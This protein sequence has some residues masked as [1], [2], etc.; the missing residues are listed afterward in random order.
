M[1]QA[2][3]DAG[4]EKR[5]GIRDQPRETGLDHAPKQELLAETRES[6]QERELGSGA[7]SEYR[8]ELANHK[9]D[10]PAQSSIRSL[11]NPDEGEKQRRGSQHPPEEGTAARLQL[12]QRRYAE[13]PA[14]THCDQ[15]Q[16]G[17]SGHGQA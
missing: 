14:Q 6:R 1:R 15:G 3:E 16:P 17:F 10:Q 7:T 8:A 9:V 11:Q 13:H 4:G 5:Q 2:E 12:R